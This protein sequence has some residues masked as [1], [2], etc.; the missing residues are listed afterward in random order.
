MQAMKV[1]LIVSQ[2]ATFG[3]WLYFRRVYPPIEG[4]M[5]GNAFLVGHLMVVVGLLGPQVLKAE[6]LVVLCMLAGPVIYNFI[7][8]YS[9]NKAYEALP[10]EARE[11]VRASASRL[12][13]LAVDA[14]SVVGALVVL[15]FTLQQGELRFSRWVFL[16]L[17]PG[18]TSILVVPS[19]EFHRRR[20]QKAVGQGRR[21]APQ[22]PTRGW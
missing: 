13:H 4:F 7:R 8:Y 15:G 20:R 12:N 21:A 10:W 9:E 22:D 16:A 19:S 18:L 2:L 17:L 3:G 1:W 11:G 5:I 6:T 14:A